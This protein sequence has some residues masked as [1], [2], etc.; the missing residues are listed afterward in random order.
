[1]LDLFKRAREEASA[2]NSPYLT[3]FMDELIR[4]HTQ[5]RDSLL[6]TKSN[7][8]KELNKILKI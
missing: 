5:K 7:F 8:Y 1:M 3:T 6:Q 2:F 4:T